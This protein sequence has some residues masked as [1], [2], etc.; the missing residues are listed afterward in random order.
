MGAAALA[1]RAALTMLAGG[2][3]SAP[4]AGVDAGLLP[5]WSKELPPAVTMGARRGLTPARGIIHLHS[6][7]SH[8]ACDGRPRDSL[9]GAVDESCLADLRAALC[10]TRVDYASLTDHD[11]TMADE[12]FGDLF[13]RRADDDLI[14]DA[15]GDSIAS[16]MRCGPE[17][18]DH[19]VLFFVGG[20]ND[21][22]PINLDHHPAGSIAERHDLY[23]REDAD[24]VAAWRALGGLVFIPHT[25]SRTLETLR[26]LG[27]D[28]LEIYNLHANIDPDIRVEY[29]G[30]PGPAAIQAVVAFADQAPTGPE[31]DLALLSFLAPNQPALTAWEQL[32]AEGRRVTASAGTDAHQ[33]ALPILLRDGER[34]D[35]YRRMIRWFANVALA[36]DAR[37][38]DAIEQALAAGRLLVVFEIFGTPVGF[39]AYATDGAGVTH[40]VGAELPLA[41]AAT[42]TATL[43]SV[44]ALDAALPRPAIRARVIRV[45]ADGAHEIAGADADIGSLDVALDQPGAYRVEV[46]ITPHHLGPYLGDLGPAYSERE[47]V[48]IT[49]NPFY[50]RADPA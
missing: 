50:V 40:E 28:G 43:P 5:A 23:N 15:A 3:C 1:T 26:A 33:N 47:Q 45:D 19:E 18:D 4:E 21:L 20:E 11:A 38:P 36:E 31:P 30:L 12:A 2:A 29:L 14:A 39:D 46:L 6:P 10:A 24:A 48:W 41:A 16:R 9:T 32:L 44:H 13:L 34:G 27:A 22:M 17:P 7:Y 8:D 25:E 42:L 37:D 35:S 49:T